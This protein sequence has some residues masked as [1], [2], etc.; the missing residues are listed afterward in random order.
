MTGAEFPGDDRHVLRDIQTLLAMV[1]LLREEIAAFGVGFTALLDLLHEALGVSPQALQAVVDQAEA[2]VAHP[3]AVSLSATGVGRVTRAQ[4]KQAIGEDFDALRA[5]VAA[6]LR[7][8]AD[9]EGPT[10]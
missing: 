7:V 3:P 10:A 4:V 8:P 9:E 5:R 2:V 6:A 1:H